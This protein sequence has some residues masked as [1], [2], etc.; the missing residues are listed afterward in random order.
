MS[1]FYAEKKNLKKHG[2]R[3]MGYFAT[4]ESYATIKKNSVWCVM[5]DGK[6]HAEARGKQKCLDIVDAMNERSQP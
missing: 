6:I 1:K 2:E 3:I 4:Y 5:L